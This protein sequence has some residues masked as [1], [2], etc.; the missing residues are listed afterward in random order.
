MFIF[1]IARSNQGLIN[2]F[3]HW[4]RELRLVQ[5]ASLKILG[6]EAEENKS[7]E[8]NYS[9]LNRSQCIFFFGFITLSLVSKDVTGTCITGL[10]IATDT[11]TNATSIFS[12]VTKNSGL[13]TTLATR[14]LYDIDLN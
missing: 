8:I 6:S 10:K 7:K 12:L 5:D 1:A 13:V 14:Y 11:L 3:E 9:S 2:A 4:S